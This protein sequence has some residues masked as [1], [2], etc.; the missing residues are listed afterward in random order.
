MI[1]NAKLFFKNKARFSQFWPV[2]LSLLRKVS[3]GA[4]CTAPTPRSDVTAL[5]KELSA[6][7]I[8][9]VKLRDFLVA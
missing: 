3:T 6:I 1:Q 7:L 5:L 8:A 2:V 4:V 9:C